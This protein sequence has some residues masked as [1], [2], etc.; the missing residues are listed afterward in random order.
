MKIEKVY[1]KNFRCFGPKGTNVRLEN[2]VTAFVGGNG[3][4]KT[5][6]FQAL[7]RNAPCGRRTST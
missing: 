3:S 7:S 5:A 4:G 6:A 1:I 2:C